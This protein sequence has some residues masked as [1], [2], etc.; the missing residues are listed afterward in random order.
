MSSAAAPLRAFDSKGHV[1][2]EA[3]VYRSLVE[4]HDG[5]PRRPDVLRD[6]F[7]DGDLSPP[8]CFGW[9]ERLPGYCSD[10]KTSNRLL[11]WPRPLTD[12]PD[13]AFRRQFSDAGQCFHFMALLEDAQTPA[14]PETSIPRGLATSALVR[15][16]GL[17]D[18]LMRQVVI[19]G[20]PGTRRSSYGLYE[21]M[22]AVGDSFSGAHT[23]RRSGSHDIDELRVWK[24]LT[25][26]PGL[27]PE[28]VAAI[29]D[30]AFHKWDDRRDKS[31]VVENRVTAS[32]KRCGS[33]TGTPYAVP[34][35]CLSEEG[36]LARQ[37]LVEMLVAVHDL[38]QA[39]LAA[40][41]TEPPPAPETAE[42]W[43]A[44]KEKWFAAAYSCRD[45]ECGAKQ[46]ADVAPGSYGFLGLD[47]TYNG[48]R[49]FFD[50]AAKGTLMKY[51]V[52]LNPF[53]Y[54]LG[55][56]VGY[57]HFTDGGGS[58]LVGLDLDLILPIGRHSS[59]GF[60]PAAWRVAFG[61][62]KTGTEL[63]TSFF[64]FDYLFTDRL[65]LTLRGPLEINWRRPAAEWSVGVGLTYTLSAA[66]LAGGSLVQ[67]H[68]EKVDRRDETWVP[69][70]APY[71]R[72]EG[73]RPT[74]YVATG[75]T[76]IET[77]SDAVEGV[78]YGDGSIGGAVMWDRDRW[79]GRFV[80]A[81]GASVAIGARRTSGESAY[82][83]GV[84]DASLRWYA[85]RVLGLS[86]TPV[87]LEGGPKIRGDDQLDPSPDVHGP[88][89]SQYY[90]QAGSRLGLAF[91][92][93]IIDLLVEA[94]T[95]A[96]SGKPFAA[97]EVLSVHL[98]IRL[99]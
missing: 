68:E 21:L 9:G 53:V 98:G 30:S 75:A 96:W 42:A 1:V 45:A 58:A 41:A 83:T 74:W 47:T 35:E 88:L 85:L 55:A 97:H 14:I 86:L 25:K 99:N 92:A 54:A 59:L 77:P 60:V 36:D 79:G 6:L 11:E 78:P 64:R 23:G 61:G 39:R 91:N 24:P 40:P 12:Q 93:G 50:V 69:P 32:G 31:Y 49:K 27:T 29:P 89:G 2:I 20:G 82:L 17:L 38:R 51:S 56:E 66:R 28:K 70:D 4:G 46:P 8:L 71:G 95:L 37:A 5:R 26:L 10:A 16:R 63:T 44:W 3:L 57:R 7:N 67:R 72:L 94:P 34:Y 48:S 81:P 87:R 22:H 19:D 90:F 15:C 18:D 62:E 43:R 84:F 65:A 76:T 13:A 52:S 33:L 80:W 73:R